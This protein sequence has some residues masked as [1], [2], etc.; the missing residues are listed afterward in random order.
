MYAK[1]WDP[2]TT[3]NS[4]SPH[5][6]SRI[7]SFFGNTI[8]VVKRTL[9]FTFTTS[10]SPYWTTLAWGLIS[11]ASGAAALAAT[12]GDGGRGVA[13]ARFTAAPD[14]ATREP[15]ATRARRTNRFFDFMNCSLREFP[16]L[17]RN[18]S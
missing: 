12:S 14:V 2:F 6:K 13:P 15:Q 16:G 5:V 7:C 9:V 17:L 18:R 10:F 3:Q 8:R 4:L 1:F 11:G